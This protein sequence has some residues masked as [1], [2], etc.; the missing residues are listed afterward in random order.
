MVS[1]TLRFRSFAAIAIALT[2]C[3]GA[4]HAQD[5]GSPAGPPNGGRGRL[6]ACRTDARTF[7]QNIE[8]GRGR[9]MACL[10]ENKAKLSPD[11][12]AALDAH[13]RTGAATAEGAV[14]P[15]QGSPPP[16][17]SAGGRRGRM[18]AC[19]ID[20]ATFC[21]SAQKGGGARLKCLKENQSKLQ[22]DCQAALA[23][24]GAQMHNLRSACKADRAALCADVAKGSGGI[25]QCLKSNRD[26]LS[27]ACGDAL[28]AVPEK[29]GPEKGG[30][31]RRADAGNG[32]LAR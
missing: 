18:A 5:A 15:A 17:A 29:G 10:V 13:G 23:Q 7:C 27:P 9:R 19:R 31:G 22:P 6:A 21:A 26:K 14:T 25:L 8:A 1:R 32:P 24:T 20:A 11:C 16:A 4:L 12:A 3:S 2:L 30:K 28:S